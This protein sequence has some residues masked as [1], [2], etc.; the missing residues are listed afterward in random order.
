MAEGSCGVLVVEDEAVLRLLL[1]LLLA[2]EDLDRLIRQEQG[3]AR[4]GVELATRTLA[5]PA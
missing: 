5:D 4:C 3:E 1:T 2:D